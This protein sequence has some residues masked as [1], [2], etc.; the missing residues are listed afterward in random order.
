MLRNS[1][2]SLIIVHLFFLTKIGSGDLFYTERVLV[3]FIYGIYVILGMMHYKQGSVTI[4][5]ALICPRTKSTP[6]P[7]SLRPPRHPGC[8]VP[9]HDDARAR[10]FESTCDSIPI[11]Y[12]IIFH[13][14]PTS[15]FSLVARPNT[16]ILFI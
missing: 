8:Y 3:L 15:L 10:E 4:F 6:V 5:K 12:V 7:F 14:L 2:V 11:Y 1:M 16:Y 9:C 13:D